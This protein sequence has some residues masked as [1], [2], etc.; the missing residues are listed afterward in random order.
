MQYVTIV[1]ERDLSQPAFIQPLAITTAPI[2][3][4]SL[5]PYSRN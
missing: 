3:A 1:S 4:N 5:P 2:T